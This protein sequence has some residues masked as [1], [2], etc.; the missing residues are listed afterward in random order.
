MSRW[1]KFQALACR[2]ISLLGTTGRQAAA[3]KRQRAEFYAAAWREAADHL[4]AD[5]TTLDQDVFV[6][7]KQEHS[8][9]VFLNYTQLDDPVALKVAGNKPLVHRMLRDCGLPTPDFEVFTLATIPAAAAFMKKHSPCVVKPAAGTGAGQGVTTGIQTPRQLK[10]AIVTAAG[11]GTRL[12]IEQQVPGSVLRL[13]FLDGVLLDAIER[14]PPTVT[15]DGVKRVTELVDD[16]NQRRLNSGYSV[17]QAIVKCDQDMIHTLSAQQLR[18]NSVPEADRVVRLKTVINDNMADENVSVVDSIHSSV[19][20]SARRAAEAVGLRLAGVDVIVQ[21]RSLCFQETG[22][23]I[24]EVNSTPGF[25]FHYARRGG[26]T[27]VA[28]PILTACLDRPVSDSAFAGGP[29]TELS[30]TVLENDS[31]ASWPKKKTESAISAGQF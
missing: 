30:D 14:Q 15:G 6:V 2:A 25:H 10:R 22:G 16:L 18:K 29:A 21:D 9:R 4:Q 12:L 31:A 7:R 27:P 28:I 20:D 26:R 5:F 8:T 23:V 24:L 17:A 19:V 3:A 11:Y 1:L 13:L